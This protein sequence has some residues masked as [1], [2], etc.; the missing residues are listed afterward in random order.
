M[1]RSTWVNGRSNPIFSTGC[2]ESTEISGQHSHGFVCGYSN[3]RALAGPVYWPREISEGDLTRSPLDHRKFSPLDLA[4]WS[5][6]TAV[7]AVAIFGCSNGQPPEGAMET[8]GRMIPEDPVEVF[9]MH[10]ILDQ[11]TRVEWRLDDPRARSEWRAESPG[12]VRPAAN[13]LVFERENDREIVSLTRDVEF[14]ATEIDGFEIEIA[15]MRRGRVLLE[16]EAVNLS[17]DETTGGEIDI[18]LAEPIDPPFHKYRLRLLGHPKWTG[19]VRKLR[20][21]F[22]TL[23]KRPATLR[24]VRAIQETLDAN[25]LEQIIGLPQKVTIDNDLRDAWLTVPG[26]QIRREVQAVNGAEL[27]F[28]FGSTAPLPIPIRFEITA[29]GRDGTADRLFE[30]V[31][32]PGSASWQEA[33]LR[34]PLM[35]GPVE[36]V[37]ETIA[38]DFDPRLGLPAFAHPRIFSPPER[39]SS[40]EGPLNVILISLDT[41]RADHLSLYGHTVETSPRIDAWA[42]ERG[43]VFENTVAAAPWT[44][45]A[46]V[47]LFTGLDA[48]RHGINHS[49][50]APGS[51][52]LLAELL[53]EAGYST[54]GITGGGFVHPQWGFAQGFESYSYFGEQMGFSDELE[55]NMDKALDYLRLERT[56]PFFLFFH[57]YEIHNPYIPREPYFE[58][59]SPPD[60]K[61]LYVRIDRVEPRP[62][63][64]FL[65]G[66]TFTLLNR[67]EVVQENYL[68]GGTDNGE[69][70]LLSNLYDSGVAFADQQIGRLLDALDELGLSRHTLIVLTSDHGEML[71]EHGL[72][73][74]LFLYEENLMVPLIIADPRGRGAGRRVESQA[75]QIDILPTILELLDRPLPE[76]IDGQSLL[77][78][79]L[80]RDGSSRPAWSYAPASNYGIALR[81]QNQLKYIS[82]NHVWPSPEIPQEEIFDLQSDPSE[83]DSIAAEDPRLE[84]LRRQVAEELLATT[85]GLRLH[86]THQGPGV[87]SGELRGEKM[88]QTAN[89]KTATAAC[90]CLETE[91]NGSARFN[92]EP[93][94]QFMVWIEDVGAGLLEVEMS[95]MHP[96]AEVPDGFLKHSVAI[97]SIEESLH[98]AWENGS[99]ETFEGPSAPIVSGIRLSWHDRYRTGGGPIAIDAELR[100]QLEALGYVTP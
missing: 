4:K 87:L 53:R 27:R 11:E 12:L 35:S 56:E 58:L 81:L 22:E 18:S 16:W 61:G 68:A 6:L 45:P 34:L 65:D 78:E 17:T 88:I 62:E 26:S 36:L 90:Q 32:E 71:G 54:R 84:D 80:G 83:S 55:S 28:A 29:V 91:G 57:T 24:A 64:G 8:F 2:P 67:G 96:G 5:G 76:P 7:L 10:S 75:R 60:Q 92:L 41:L 97:E 38:N 48:H 25:G 74:H 13:G 85:P 77:P 23:R 49:Q 100:S 1:R 50:P 9:Q 14:K 73:T 51:L 40:S 99:W 21:V 37:F 59:M 63:Q 70:A 42:G 52:T 15:G 43:T 39:P 3:C 44:L 30:A 93:G 66:R 69:D 72:A 33:R 47:S 46:H 98:L 95:I 79:M 31:S 86:F 19:E 94:E 82:K 89:L 20:F